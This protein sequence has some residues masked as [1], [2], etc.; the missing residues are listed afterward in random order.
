[1]PTI[2][3][4]GNIDERKTRARAIYLSSLDTYTLR[5][6]DECGAQFHLTEE[7]VDVD[8]AYE[9]TTNTWQF[10]RNINCPSCKNYVTS[11]NKRVSLVTP[12]KRGIDWEY[13]LS[14]LFLV[15]VVFAA[16]QLI[17]MVVV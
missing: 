4:E 2:I 8:P 16:L 9:S 11:I 5:T 3:K 12:K 13:F 15:A 10:Y 7:D 6:C 14:M 17:L 1:M